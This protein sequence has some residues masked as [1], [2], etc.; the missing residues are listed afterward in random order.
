MRA[1]SFQFPNIYGLFIK[2][3]HSALLNASE[4]NHY[5]KELD[6]KQT[7]LDTRRD[8]TVRLPKLKCIYRPGKQK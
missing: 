2:R 7:N 4:A 3:G 6:T 5:D 1:D 8:I